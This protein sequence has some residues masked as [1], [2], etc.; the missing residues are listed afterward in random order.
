MVKLI[1]S[2]FIKKALLGEKTSRVKV[3][4]ASKVCEHRLHAIRNQ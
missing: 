2:V 3:N 1:Y 4:C